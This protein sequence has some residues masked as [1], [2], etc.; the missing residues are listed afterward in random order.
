MIYYGTLYIVL[1]ETS[2]SLW[3]A[4]LQ[5]VGIEWHYNFSFLLDSHMHLYLVFCFGLALY[6]MLDTGGVFVLDFRN[7][8][9]LKILSFSGL[10]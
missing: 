7:W 6:S 10:N 3:V 1:I 4:K 2:C 5:F 8:M 9:L